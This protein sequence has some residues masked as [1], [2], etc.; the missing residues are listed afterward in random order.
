MLMLAV[1]MMAG[2]SSQSFGQI[3]IGVNAGLGL[4]MGDFGDSY[5]MGFGGSVEGKYFLNE[6]IAVGATFGYYSFTGKDELLTALSLGTESSAD[7]KFTIMPILATVDYYFA[8]EGFKP[9]V[10]AGVGLYSWKSKVTIPNYGDYEV[11]GSD[12]GVAPTVGFCYGLSEKIDLNVNAK[13]NMI[14]TEGSSTTYLG[15]NVG[16]IF[17]L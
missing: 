10:G 12:F 15:V 3:K 11:T 16:I 13:Y 17:A 2:F 9:Y 8:T 5:K 6:N 14:F 7:A 4:P 1:V